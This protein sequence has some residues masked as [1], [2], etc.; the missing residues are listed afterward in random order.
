MLRCTLRRASKKEPSRRGMIRVRPPAVYQGFDPD[1]IPPKRAATPC[2]SG[3][4][5][6]FRLRQLVTG[7]GKTR[8]STTGFPRSAAAWVIW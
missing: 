6:R 7:C 3:A 1:D 4:A 2:L 8:N 5:T